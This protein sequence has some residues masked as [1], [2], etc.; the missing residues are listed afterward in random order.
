MLQECGVCASAFMAQKK[1]RSESVIAATKR[2]ER[3]VRTLKLISLAALLIGIA[4]ILLAAEPI[5]A[6]VFLPQP[7]FG[8]SLSQINQP[9][10]P[11]QLA[12]IN[13]ASDLYFE[14]A[15]ELYLNHSIT[16]MTGYV[17]A[18][19][20]YFPLTKLSKL[21]DS[22]TLASTTPIIV[23]AK[24][25]VLYL[26]AISCIYC[27]ENRWAMAL[28]LGR[29]GNFSSLYTGY[30]S[31]GDGDVPTLYWLPDNYTT[32]SAVKF[33][34]NYTSK[35]VSFLSMEYLS[36]ITAGF[37]LPSSGLSFFQQQAQQYRDQTYIN[38]TNFLI[39][40]NSYTGSQAANN[41]F[42]G[43]PYTIWGNYIYG[44]ATASAFSNGTTEIMNMTHQEIFNQLGKPDNVFAWEQYIGAD[45]YIAGVCSTINNTAP[46]CSLP[47]IQGIEAIGG[48]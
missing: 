28:A 5:L 38:A 45:F 48:F 20:P 29:F 11:V 40:I 19:A 17:A 39:G 30:S 41:T 23:D 18:G 7:Q 43:T 15:G 8:H 24:P 44:G 33:G 25:T 35:Y 27:G 9:L 26:G 16:T 32:K 34:N 42:S 10:T 12:V 13:N 47:A 36:P 3:A 6:S 46:I 37:E 31:F 4:A 1:E 21:P 14:Q 2:L 22:S